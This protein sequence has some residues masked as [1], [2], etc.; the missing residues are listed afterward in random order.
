MKPTRTPLTIGQELTLAWSRIYTSV[1]TGP[2]NGQLPSAQSHSY[3]H[4]P[5]ERIDALPATTATAALPVIFIHGGGCTMGRKESY[6]TALEPLMAAGHTVFN[7]EYPKAPDHPHPYM[8]RSIFTALAWCKRE[9][10][11]KRAHLVGDSAGGT[12]ALMAALIALNPGLRQ[13]IEPL[14][15]DKE[16]P[17]IASVACLY[18]V[19]DR[20]SCFDETIPGGSAMIA[21]YGGQDALS[22]TVDADHAITPMDVVFEKHPPFF[23]G[24]GSDDPLKRSSELYRDR[25]TEDEH[26]LTFKLYDG[27]MHGFFNVLHDRHRDHLVKDVLEFLARTERA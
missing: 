6:Q 24:V 9:H 23:I 8:L 11:V 19:F 13:P 25:L 17:A 22:E 2:F 5:D 21:A 12:L 27:A 10:G 26:P 1:V 3:G 18:S 16:L 14:P 20:Q 15:K 7:I 4:H